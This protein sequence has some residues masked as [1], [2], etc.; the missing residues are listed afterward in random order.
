M[1]ARRQHALSS[2]RELRTSIEVARA[3]LAA[4]ERAY[5]VLERHADAYPDRCERHMLPTDIKQWD[6]RAQRWNT[7]K[8]KCPCEGKV[9][10]RWCR[11]CGQTFTRCE[12]HGESRSATDALEMHRLT[13]HGITTRDPAHARDREAEDEGRVSER[14]APVSVDSVQA[15]LADRGR[16]REAEDQQGQG[17]GCEADHDPTEPTESRNDQA[18]AEVGA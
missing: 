13:E 6:K 1:N 10:A 18:G 3:D 9:I 5:D 2:I 8:L 16:N 7:A 4:L 15:S 12:A 17:E 14:S 11:E